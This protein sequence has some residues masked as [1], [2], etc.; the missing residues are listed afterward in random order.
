MRTKLLMLTALTAMPMLAYSAV[1]VSVG[2]HTFAEDGFP[3]LKPNEQASIFYCTGKMSGP[4]AMACAVAKC[5]KQFKVPAN[6]ATKKVGNS[7]LIGGKCIA[8]GWSEKKG[9]SIV[10]VGPKGDNQFIM[11]K[12]LGDPT[13]EIAMQYVAS[14][15]FP[16]SKGT[17]V[18]DYWDKGE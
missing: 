18:L 8:D 13:R 10:M 5:K 17:I 7:D 16:V 15:D 3:T 6:A 11:S 1:G 4:E 12:A 14:N 9:H 2:H